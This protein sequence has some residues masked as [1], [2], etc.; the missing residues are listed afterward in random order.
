MLIKRSRLPIRQMLTVGLLPSPIKVWWYKLKGARI[1]PGVSIG[2]CSIISANSMEIDADTSI[3][4]FSYISSAGVKIGKRTAIRSFI[5]IEAQEVIIGND[6]TISEMALIRTLVPSPKSQIVIHDRVH[7]FPFSIIDP[8]RKVEIGE[9]SSVGYD[10]YIFTHG[11]YKS[12][13]DGYPVEFGEVHIGKRVWIPSRV[14]IMP[15]VRIGDDAVVGSGALVNRDIPSG[16]LAVG[17]PAKVIKTKEQYVIRYSDEEKLDMLTDILDEFCQHLQ[18][19]A[20]VAWQRESGGEYPL[21]RVSVPKIQKSFEL[22]L[23]V[24]ASSATTN[25]ASVVLDSVPAEKQRSWNLDGKVWFS[26]GSRCCSEYLDD[27]GEE[28]RDFF[29]R[30]GLYFARP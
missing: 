5:A 14:F 22:E 24:S 9:E 17:V 28:L 6:V 20:R 8:S 4:M 29:R 27:L 15:S 18:D 19:Y 7:I 30:Y 23:I 10:T 13:L 2:L 12:K 25:R 21:W 11:A 26:I 16:A 3:G 1:G